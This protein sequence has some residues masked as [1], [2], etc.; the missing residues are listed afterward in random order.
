M[1]IINDNIMEYTDENYNIN[2][3]E[4]DLISLIKENYSKTSEKTV[5]TI[6]KKIYNFNIKDLFRAEIYKITFS[7]KSYIIFKEVAI[8]FHK[9]DNIIKNY[10]FQIYEKIINYDDKSHL[11]FSIM[12]CCNHLFSL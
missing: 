3:L 2:L 8:K 7:G 10:K 9:G 6:N 1:D 5:L 12:H 11:N 4:I